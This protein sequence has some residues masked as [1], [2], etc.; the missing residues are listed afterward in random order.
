MTTRGLWMLL[1]IFTFFW[2]STV[3]GVAMRLA[4]RGV[5]GWWAVLVFGITSLVAMPVV[6]AR[7]AQ[8]GSGQSAPRPETSA[9]TKDRVAADAA[10]VGD[11]TPREQEV[12][13]LLGRG[14][15]NRQIAQELYVSQATVKS[16][17]N[18]ICRKL[19]AENRTHAV[20]IARERGLLH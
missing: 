12:L 8:P 14:R 17:V 13:R 10:Y 11:L 5:G 2:G 16:H 18:A 15:T 6:A 9:A 1:A 4:D 7:L 20:A 19:A 3:L